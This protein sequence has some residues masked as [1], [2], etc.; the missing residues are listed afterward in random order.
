LQDARLSHAEFDLPSI[1]PPSFNQ[2]DET[3]VVPLPPPPPTPTLTLPKSPHRTSGPS[4]MS[5]TEMPAFRSSSGPR[6]VVFFG[7]GLALLAAGYVFARHRGASVS[8]ASTEP[9]ATAALATAAPPPPTQPIV[10]RAVETTPVATPGTTVVSHVSPE[11]S[12]GV[13]SSPP[14]SKA[15]PPAAASAKPKAA[16]APHPAP[17]QGGKGEELDVG[18]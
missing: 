11:A 15:S 10:P 18:F 5:V 9:A 1:R 4:S 14:K 6:R 3:P 13:A 7:L 2:A 8:I 16:P 12:P 17:A